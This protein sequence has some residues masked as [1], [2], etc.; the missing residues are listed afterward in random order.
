MPSTAHN[1]VDLERCELNVFTLLRKQAV[2]HFADTV[3]KVS[4]D[5]QHQNHLEPRVTLSVAVGDNLQAN[6]LQAGLNF[7][8]AYLTSIVN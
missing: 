1:Q 6:N 5:F 2:R 8:N 7:T 3:Q 4:C